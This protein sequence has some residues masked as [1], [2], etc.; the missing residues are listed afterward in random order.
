MPHINLP[1][2]VPGIRSL[3]SF[4]PETAAPL[5]LLAQTLLHNPHPTL[6]AGERELIATYVSSL[7]NCKYCATI[8]GAIAKHQLGNDGETVK[9]LVTDME[10][11]PVSDKLKALLRIAAKVQTGGQNVTETD[12]AEARNEGATDL[13]IH[14]TVLI[15]AAFCMYNRYVD[16]LATF[17]PD[18]DELYDQMGAIRAREG[19]HSGPLTLKKNEAVTEA[20]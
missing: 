10:N 1:A 16:G 8:H 7:N 11:A 2:G 15:A 3:F 9:R 4:R 19:Y 18:D 6:T 14:D 12:V 5:N 17:Q 20:S 13:E